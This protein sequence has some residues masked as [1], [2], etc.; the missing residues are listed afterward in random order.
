[1]NPLDL[2]QTA[3]N[4]DNSV[5]PDFSDLIGPGK[6]MMPEDL[7]R[8]IR[9]DQG[10]H[11]AQRANVIQMLNNP[12]IA[13]HVLTGLTGAGIAL[14]V[15]RWKKMSTTS[16][17]LMSLAGFGLGNIILNKLTPSPKFTNWSPSGGTVTVL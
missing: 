14:A 13:T 1:M 16:Q 6:M 3:T 17:V 8:F 7:T 11:P 2:I 9:Q 10:L 5:G 15:A 12:D 4:G